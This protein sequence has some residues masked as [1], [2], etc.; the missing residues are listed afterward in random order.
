[1]AKRSKNLFRKLPAA[2][3]DNQNRKGFPGIRSTQDRRNGYLTD[4]PNHIAS[5]DLRDRRVKCPIR[6]NRSNGIP[7]R[8]RRKGL[9]GIRSTQVRRNG[10]LTDGPNHIASSDLRDRR[11][12]CPIRSNR[13]NGIPGRPRRNSLPVY[14]RGRIACSP[15]VCRGRFGRLR[16]VLFTQHSSEEPR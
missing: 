16:P 11:V 15:T 8:P 1:M 14:L 5:S 13:S 4:G 10:Y 2:L 3:F 12:K 7:G 9:P 6:S